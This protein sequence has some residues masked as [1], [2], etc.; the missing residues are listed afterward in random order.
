MNTG[1]LAT[2]ELADGRQRREDEQLDADLNTRV[3][4]SF[5]FRELLQ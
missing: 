1:V 3:N 5:P 4:H 2:R